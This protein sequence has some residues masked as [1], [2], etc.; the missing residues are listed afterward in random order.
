MMQEEIPVVYNQY[1]I[2]I[3]HVFVYNIEF[4]G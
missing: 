4:R 1:E 3:P 2:T